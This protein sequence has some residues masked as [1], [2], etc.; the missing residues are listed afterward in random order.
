[1]LQNN[2]QNFLFAW[3]QYINDNSKLGFKPVY[4]AV[5]TDLTIFSC[6]N[7]DEFYSV[8]HCYCSSAKHI[9]C[10]GFLTANE[11]TQLFEH[12]Q[13]SKS[14]YI[15][16]NKIVPVSESEITFYPYEADNE[17]AYFR[18]HCAYVG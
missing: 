15:S 12:K 1:M 6:E 13:F 3:M 16:G 17:A 14:F 9:F 18:N 2:T 10:N 5:R 11:E 7:W 4:F 8:T